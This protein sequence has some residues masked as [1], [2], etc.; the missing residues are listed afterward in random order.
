VTDLTLADVH[1]FMRDVTGGRT[2]LEEKTE[3]LRGKSI[4]EGG[5]GAAARTVGLLGGILSFAVSE[6]VIPSNP[7]QGVRR[8]ADGTRTTRLTPAT[9]RLLGRALKEPGPR[10]RTPWR[11]SCIWFL[12]LT[13]C[14]EGEGEGLVWG[15]VDEAGQA[16]RLR[17]SK[18]GAPAQSL[19]A[20]R[21]EGRARRG[22]H[23]AHPAAQLRL[24]RRPPELQRRDH[25]RDA[26]ARVGHRHPALHPPPRRGASP[27]L[28]ASQARS[29]GR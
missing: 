5:R 28:T 29:G 9:Y 10:G 12:A 11:W 17:D 19:R 25:R 1:R 14:R 18:E 6:G 3:R 7:A 26:R 21:E 23:A 15:E 13:G 20:D 27:P 2:A 8:P 24:H 4:V 16:L 22:G